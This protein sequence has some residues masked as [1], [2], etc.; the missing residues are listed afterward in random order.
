MTK[1]IAALAFSLIITLFS[2]AQIKKDSFAPPLRIPLFLTGNFGE[3]RVNHFHSGL[4]F[5]T[6]GTIGFP[7][8]SFDD[9]YISRVMISVHGNGRALYVN[10]P[11]GTTTVYLHLDR[12]M[13]EMETK[14]EDFQY[15]EETYEINHYFKENEVRVKR[16]EQ[17]AFSGNSGSSAG[18]HLH[19]EL[20]DTK[21][22]EVMD[23]IPYFRNLIK[24]H[25]APQAREVVVYP[26]FYGGVINGKMQKTFL[27]VVNKS[28]RQTPE[29]W[30]KIALGIKAFDTKDGVGNVYGVKSIQL[31]VDNELISDYK[32]DRYAFKN[33]RSVNSCIDYVEW[34]HHRSS[35]LKSYIDPG[36]KIGIFDAMKN[37]G[38]FDIK[39]ERDYKVKYV[40]T[41]E[42]G[43]NSELNFTLKG[44]RQ[45]IPETTIDCRNKLFCDKPSF[46]KSTNM[47][48]EL[49]LGVLYDDLCLNYSSVP[50]V[51]YY[52]DLHKIHTPNVPLHNFCTLELKVENDTVKD[53]SKYYLVRISGHTASY[54]K[55]EYKKGWVKGFIRE[56]GEY[57]VVADFRPPTI[58]KLKT[59]SNDRIE[60]RISD[61]GSGV[62]SYRGTIDGKFALF[63]MD[64]KRGVIVCKL[65][66]KH[67]IAHQQHQLKM[68]VRDNCD[69]ESQF[70][71]EFKW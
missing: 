33:T 48:L 37:G 4:D 62:A 31:F 57:A 58:T 67:V 66:P 20:R 26:M 7:V 39:E 43:N 25:I 12:F 3:I 2:S 65:S 49:P 19:F 35:I 60:F 29:V 53:K 1:N 15:K 8:Y 21:T 55:S 59:N 41:D 28:I 16:G 13:P 42:Y 54:Q 50:S 36:N 10:H 30:G 63:A 45:V 9:G 64:T 69:N 51:S 14:L 27:Q 38:I 22:E 32:I 11:N 56:F 17:I 34:I 52:S 61:I 6:Q 46:F 23:P 40:L 47:H 5:K 70:Q 24:D 68:M 44:K 71:E 18:P